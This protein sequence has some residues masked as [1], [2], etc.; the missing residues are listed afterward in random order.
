MHIMNRKDSDIGKS[1]GCLFCL[2]DCG[3]VSMNSET[4]GEENGQKVRTVLKAGEMAT[5]ILP[6]RFMILMRRSVFQRR[7]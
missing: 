1:I 4:I 2:M 5:Y 3:L 6:E 7:L